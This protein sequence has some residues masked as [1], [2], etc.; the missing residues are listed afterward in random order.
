METGAA[1]C[2]G[3]L[4]GFFSVA[5][6]MLGDRH[7]PATERATAGTVESLRGL[8]ESWP[9]AFE[10]AL[11]GAKGGVAVLLSLQDALRMAEVLSG[12]PVASTSALD[13]ATA[14]ILTELAE[15]G[16][17][18]AVNVLAQQRGGG[19]SGVEQVRVHM[20]GAAGA[21]ELARRL[22]G[23]FHQATFR[24]SVEGGAQGAGAV[25]FA[26]SLAAHEEAVPQADAGARVTLSQ[27]E[28]GDILGG[29]DAAVA[30]ERT[31]TMQ[32][33]LDM[34]L[35]IR[36]VATA[37]LGRVELPISEILNFGPGSII[38]I[39][40]L[41]DEPVDLLVNDK[42]IARGDVVVVDERFGLRITE[43]VSARERI[44]SL[45]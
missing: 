4:K 21:E 19:P 11:S 20:P 2:D 10:A 42:L 8:L 5:D 12:Q 41:V 13:T 44:E 45:G 43:I 38:E 22:G 28:L 15:P 36:L 39:G 31:G 26:S 6:A 24:Y 37:R 27:E 34:I 18:S 33:N 9:V 23:A 29:F 40:H 7:V 16:L 14:G 17:G 35:D 32:N 1:V 30:A 3:L 25:L